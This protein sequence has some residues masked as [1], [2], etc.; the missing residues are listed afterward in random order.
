MR[1]GLLCLLGLGV[2]HLVLLNA[3]VRRPDGRDVETRGHEWVVHCDG[4]RG[5]VKSEWGGG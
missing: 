1:L 3:V 2:D 5:A 4:G